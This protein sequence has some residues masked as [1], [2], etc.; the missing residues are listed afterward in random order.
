M[1]KVFCDRCGKEINTQKDGIHTQANKVFFIKDDVFEYGQPQ[2]M[3]V[4]QNGTAITQG[5][6]CDACLD[7]IK[8]C[9][10]PIP[11]CINDTHNL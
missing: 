2:L 3:E 4:V 1:I 6:I 10:Q 8:R 9:C 7:D 5:N 11:Q